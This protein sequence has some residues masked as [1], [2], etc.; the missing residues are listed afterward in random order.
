METEQRI[1]P[2]RFRSSGK[3]KKEL[4]SGVFWL[5][6]VLGLGVL[7]ACVL[8]PQWL[9]YQELAQR[10]A[11]LDRRLA[12]ARLDLKLERQAVDAAQHDVAFNERLLIEELNYSRPGE[13]ILLSGSVEKAQPDS[14]LASDDSPGPAWLRAF[15]ERD[16]RNILLMMS[17]GLVLFAFV[18][19]PPGRRVARARPRAR[20]PVRPAPAAFADLRQTN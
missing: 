18:Y 3:T 4:S 17:A 12:Q 14:P 7:G 6:L 10:Q 11:R 5:L 16:S 8:V 15:S 13:Q 1:P 2:I 9:E 20:I 19:Y